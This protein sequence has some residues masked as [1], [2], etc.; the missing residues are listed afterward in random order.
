MHRIHSIALERNPESRKA[1]EMLEAYFAESEPFRAEAILGELVAQYVQPTAT[2]IVA[3]RLRSHGS[4]HY[5]Q[6]EDVTSE[7]V[8]AFLLYVEDQS[9]VDDEPIRNVE[10]FA[11]TLAGRACND[12]VRR[13][14][15]A[16]HGLRNKL[17]HLF[18]T[19]PDIARWKNKHGEWICG[20]VKWQVAAVTPRS[21]VEEFSRSVWLEQSSA[22][23]ADQLVRVFGQFG[24]PVRFNDLALV[25]ARLWNVQETSAQPEEEELELAD[26]STPVDVTLGRK[27]WLAGLWEQIGKLN[28]NQRTALLLNL[29]TPD[30]SCAASLLVMTGVVSVRKIAQ[31]VEMPAEEFVE[32]WKRMP[33]S[34]IEIAGLLGL[35]RQQVINL[36]KCA[37]ERLA[38]HTGVHD[39]GQW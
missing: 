36:R 13:T 2:R 7:A 14:R 12:H 1:E 20:L 17:R 4:A 35:T 11:A 30:G 32:I 22:H 5:G 37:R 23:P 25:M 39:R 31:A 34:D 8:V 21:D 3:S 38:R 24:A 33:L 16:F 6:I 9:G 10:A 18:E 15:P 27:E 28:R 26:A 19:C 29:R